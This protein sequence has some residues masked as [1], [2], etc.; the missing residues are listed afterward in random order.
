MEL[1][2]SLLTLLEAVLGVL[3]A[4]GAAIAPW[5]PLIA[6]VAFW[7]LAV[8]WVKLREYL[9][10]GGVIGVLLIAAVMVLVWGIVA[11]PEDGF[12]HL[13]G[14]HVTNFFGKFMYVTALLVIMLLC[15]SVQLT[16]ALDRYLHFVEPAD[17]VHEEHGHGDHDSHGDHASHS[18]HAA[19]NGHAH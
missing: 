4:L 3:A 6:W 14:L 10:A 8:D 5:W 11:P 9:L 16:G 17:D 7:S 12:H 18:T 15:G 2:N 1:L 19:H 13:L